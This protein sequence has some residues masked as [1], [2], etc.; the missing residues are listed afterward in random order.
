[1]AVYPSLYRAQAV[2]V[3]GSGVT[4]FV[5]QV[6]GDAPIIVRQFLGAPPTRKEMGWVMFQAGNPAHPVW[7]SGVV[8]T[9][10]EGGGDEGGGGEVGASFVYNQGSPSATWVIVHDLGFRPNV[11]VEDSAGTT[12][13]GEVVYNNDNQLT[14][15]FSAA[16]SGIAYLS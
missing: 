6:F 13:E 9:V 1:M 7:A 2:D 16:F 14:L 10:V 5:P 15:T 8:T 12:I 4:A 11:T 3:S